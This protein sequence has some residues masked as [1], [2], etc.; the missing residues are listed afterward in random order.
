MDVLDPFIHD[1]KTLLDQYRDADGNQVYS[2]QGE[3]AGVNEMGIRDLPEFVCPSD[4][5]STGQ[6]SKVVIATQPLVNATNV[7]DD[8]GLK[9]WDDGKSS[10]G[11]KGTNFIANGGVCGG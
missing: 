9:Y 3:I 5:M 6:V 11:F 1:M 2:W 8:M 4:D 10:G 7:D